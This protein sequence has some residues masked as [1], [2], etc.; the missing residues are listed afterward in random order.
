MEE[1]Q[2]NIRNNIKSYIPVTN[3]RYL[4]RDNSF[5]FIPTDLSI[6]FYVYEAK[7]MVHMFS[8]PYFSF[9]IHKN[10]ELPV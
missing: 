1:Q 5:L 7:Q 10:M 3:I 2:T 9:S 8:F 6:K 4:T